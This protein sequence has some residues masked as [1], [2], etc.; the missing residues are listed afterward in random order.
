MDT[1]ELNELKE[2]LRQL[3][4]ELDIN[5]DKGWIIAY[6]IYKLA[7]IIEGGIEE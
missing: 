2:T 1:S 7:D 6:Y 3:A 5:L 4:I